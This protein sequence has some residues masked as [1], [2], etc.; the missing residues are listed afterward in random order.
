MKINFQIYNIGLLL[1][2]TLFTLSCKKNSPQLIPTVSPFE[3][4]GVSDNTIQGKANITSDGGTSIISRGVCWSTNKDPSIS[5]FK[6]ADG[7]GIGNYTSSINGLLP[8]L[9]Y[10][11]RSYAV[12]SV[13]TGYGEQITVSTLS[14]VP[15]IS[16]TPL[17]DVTATTLTSGGNIMSDGGSPILTRGVCWSTNHDPSYLDTKTNEGTG[18]GSFIS[19]VTG[20][21]PGS[22]NQIRAF[23]VNKNG[24]SY[25]SILTIT[26]PVMLPTITTSSA[27]NITEATAVCGGNI[28]SNGGADILKRGVCWSTTT[29]PTINDNKSSDGTDIGTFISNLNG[30]PPSTIWLKPNTMYFV[31]AY[32][33][34][35]MGTSYGNEV[36]F[37]TKQGSGGTVTDVDGN[38]YHTITIGTQVWFLENLRVTHYQNGDPIPNITDNNSWKGLTT[39]AY[40]W[41]NND[42]YYKST[43]GA[44]YNYYTTIDP[45]NMC[46]VGSHVPTD[47]EWLT[48]MNYLGGSGMAAAKLKEAG[49]AHWIDQSSETTNIS[50]FTALPGGYR[51][52]L[53]S[54]YFIGSNGF[55]YSKSTF[56]VLYY[57]KGKGFSFLAIGVDSSDFEHTQGISVRCLKD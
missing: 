21:K 6:T 48:L 4:I 27:S 12:N 31:R 37:T 30:L 29:N 26:T 50:G 32:A 25:G 42:I 10:Y 39:G 43:Y 46:P 51:S 44:L 17:T 24:I 11:I 19:L 53:G 55:Y 20:L 13:G 40:S 33:T 28:T 52:T 36:S 45:R 5:D 56:D 57:N 16:T 47:A 14:T 7:T 41:Y 23:A 38:V 22:I 8:G 3:V 18:T 2:V 1:I 34:N 35:N 15:L 9:T 54:F 49:Q